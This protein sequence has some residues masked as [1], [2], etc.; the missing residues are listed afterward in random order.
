MTS[1]D[2]SVC[3]P[4]RDHGRFLEEAVA[5]ALAQDDVSLEVI[6][7]DDASTDETADVMAGIED[8]RVRL[9]RHADPVGVAANRNS[10]LAA[11]RGHH[12]AWL[13]ADDAYLPGA[14]ARQHEV[15]RRHPGVVLVHGGFEVV[16]EDGGLQPRWAAPF[17]TDAVEP[18]AVAFRQLLASNEITTSTV[19]ARRTGLRAAGPFTSAAGA[20][21]SDWAMWLRLALRG[22][23]AYTAAPVARYRQHE[24]S[25]SAV[26]VRTG[27]RLHCD[28]RIARAVLRDEEALLPD[29]PGLA[30]LSRA[31]LASK[32][33]AYAGDAHVR[34][35]R[36]AALGAIRLAGRLAPA[37]VGPFA[38]ALGL[39]TI[40]HDDRGWLRLSR[41]IVTRLGPQLEGTR[42]G[43]RVRAAAAVDPEWE[44]TLARI[45]RVVRRVVPPDARVASVAKWDP[46]LLRLSRRSGQ[47]FPDLRQVPEGHPRESTT[48]IEHL[49]AVRREGI[50]HLVFPSASFWWL[51]HYTAFERHLDRYTSTWRDADCR[52]YDVRESSAVHP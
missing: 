10:C 19:L 36:S 26:T 52:I 1:P 14:L 25:I 33:I 48:V 12:V 4:A 22:D 44:A 11:A 15:L 21:G 6:V 32:A 49:E 50:S 27:E 45:A 29:S 8:P 13:D 28:V 43:G 7:H 35:R 39:A 47:N 3:I 42:H 16:D 30:R 2:V 18:S 9:L 5:S 34:R 51:D 24:R 17:A 23:V 38:P 20:S 37:E 40:R 46:T 41:K 31:A